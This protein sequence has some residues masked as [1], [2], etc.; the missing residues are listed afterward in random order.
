MRIRW[1]QNQSKLIDH[2]TAHQSFQVTFRSFLSTVL[3]DSSVKAIVSSVEMTHS[4][5]KIWLIELVNL[6]TYL[7][8]EIWIKSI[9]QLRWKEDWKKCNIN[10]PWSLLYDDKQSWLKWKLHKYN[11]F[12]KYNASIINT[13][14][15]YSEDVFIWKACFEWIHLWIRRIFTITTSV[16]KKYL[17]L[18]L[19]LYRW[20][21]AIWSVWSLK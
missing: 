14:I 13:S 7:N 6:F 19:L 12:S 20:K 16:K 21:E 4:S 9:H 3:I 11:I 10:F 5:G 15:C 2:L 1:M 17:C 8:L 18:T